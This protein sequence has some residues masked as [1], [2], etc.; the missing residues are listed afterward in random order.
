MGNDTT[1]DDRKNAAERVSERLADALNMVLGEGWEP[2]VDGMTG[3]TW[4]VGAYHADADVLVTMHSTNDSDRYY[5][6]AYTPEPR[7]TGTGETPVEALAAMRHKLRLS[8]A[9]LETHYAAMG[10]CL[11]EELR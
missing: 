2:K 9:E 4:R 5:K 8:I 6:A 3:G 7:Y 1:H 10:E 11:P